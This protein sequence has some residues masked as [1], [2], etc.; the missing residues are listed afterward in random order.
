MS[1]PTLW[2][3][4]TVASEAVNRVG[5]HADADWLSAAHR[6]VRRLAD[7]RNEFT[8]DDVW[9]ALDELDVV[10]HEPRAMG[11]VMRQAARGG[12]IVKSDR[13]RNSVRVECHARPVAVWI[14]RRMNS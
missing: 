3:A 7:T 10:T 12:V 14:S 4:Q 13:V 9:A 1:Q 11:A 8:T 2:D 5:A 6:I